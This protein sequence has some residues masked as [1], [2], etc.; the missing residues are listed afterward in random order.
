MYYILILIFLYLLLRFCEEGVEEV[1]KVVI[2]FLRSFR[3][4]CCDG[5]YH[6]PLLAFDSVFV[7]IYPNFL[8]ISNS[9]FCQNQLGLSSMRK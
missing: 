9:I 2:K 3:D 7:N 8:H 4:L 6:S 1:Y 5:R